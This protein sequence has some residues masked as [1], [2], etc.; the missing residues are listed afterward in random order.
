[1]G[2]ATISLT[3]NTTANIHSQ[4]SEDLRKQFLA[5]DN[6][7]VEEKVSPPPA[8]TLALH[9]LTAFIIQHKDLALDVG[10]K[11]VL[12]VWKAAWQRW[13]TKAKSAEK[14]HKDTKLAKGEPHPSQAF[15]YATLSVGDLK[16]GLPATE[17]EIKKFLDQVAKTKGGS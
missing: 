3:V 6:L 12:E 17:Q 5:L 14:E 2:R 13:G 9:E 1:M 8:D 4:L 7:G 10:I 16:L 11:M 15:D